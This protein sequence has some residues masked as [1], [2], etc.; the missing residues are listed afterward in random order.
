MQ[1]L[2]RD[3]FGLLFD[4]V[5]EEVLEGY[6][7]IFV[8][9]DLRGRPEIFTDDSPPQVMDLQCMVNDL[10]CVVQV[11]DLWC[12]VNHLHYEDEQPALKESLDRK[13]TWVIADSCTIEEHTQKA[14]TLS[15]CLVVICAEEPSQDTE[16]LRLGHL[17]AILKA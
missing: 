17:L 15:D 10:E 14:Q 9:D 6:D 1:F 3:Y 11:F 4:S 5:P 2:N 16:N 13:V 7:L 8:V 12:L